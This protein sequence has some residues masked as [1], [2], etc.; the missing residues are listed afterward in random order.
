MV[1]DEEEGR[2]VKCSNT[3]THA[4]SPGPATFFGSC[5]GRGIISTLSGIV[6][7]PGPSP[8]RIPT[9]P[10]RERMPME[11]EPVPVLSIVLNS[12]SDHG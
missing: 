8:P 11:P 9:D 2:R 3:L 7:D 5:T 1:L 6:R 10:G 4:H 12:V